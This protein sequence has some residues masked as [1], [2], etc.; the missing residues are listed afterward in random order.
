[1]TPM[2][3]NRVGR[4]LHVPKRIAENSMKSHMHNRKTIK[5]FLV[6]DHVLIREG[7]KLQLKDESDIQIVGEAS[8][9][10]EAVEKVVDCAPD[11]VLM[12]INMPF[13]NGMEATKTLR[14]ICPNARVLVLTASNCKENITE[15]NRAGAHG[16][17]LK[18]VSASEL[19]QAI[20]TVA[21]GQKFFT[22]N[23][24]ETLLNDSVAQQEKV[25]KA[26]ASGLSPREQEVLISELLTY[27]LC[28]MSAF[29][30]SRAFPDTIG[31]A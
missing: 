19:S 25:S 22:S 7:I 20:R 6:D 3:K 30:H 21:N 13:M 27:T 24:A 9:G 26:K 29:C 2:S 16:Y 8:N 10:K 17:V 4:T 18:D 14:E 23:I 12:D 15:L 28:K 31:Q 1:M 11:V 5:L